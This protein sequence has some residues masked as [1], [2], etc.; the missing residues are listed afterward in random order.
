MSCTQISALRT[1]LASVGNLTVGS[2]T[3]S[4]VSADLTKIET[5]LTSL[6]NDPNSLYSAEVSEITADLSVLAEQARGLTA[7]PSATIRTAVNE[8]KRAVDV[9]T[10]GMRTDCP[11]S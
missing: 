7:H 6:K 9:V 3:G 2:K 4:Q 1:A 11:S 10:T 8:L 5:A